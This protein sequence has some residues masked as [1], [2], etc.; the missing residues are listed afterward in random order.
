MIQ[1]EKLSIHL[2]LFFRYLREKKFLIG[3]KE[4]SDGLRALE[5]IDISDIQQ[6]RLAL[7]IV[8]CSSR[9]EQETFDHAFIKFFLNNNQDQQ[10]EDLLHVLTEKKRKNEE[11]N[12]VNRTVESKEKSST[13]PS[14]NSA[15]QDQITD[16]NSGKEQKKMAIW[17]ATNL[18]NKDEQ[19]I[20]ASISSAQFETMEK[21]AKTFVQQ[22]NLK[23]LRRYKVMKNGSKF[24]IRRTLRQSIQ[25]GGYPIKPVWTGP[26]KEKANFI[27]LCDSSRS[28]SAY[29]EPFLQFA[30]AMTKCTNNVEVFLFSTKLRRVTDQFKRT[31]QDEF[32]V[33]TIKRNEWGG[34]TCI[35]ESLY[36]FVQQYGMYVKK[37]T[38]VF[39]A[40][41]GLD[42]GAIDHLQ[43]AM[44][45]IHQ[46]TSAVIW[47]NPLL[48]IEGYEPIA[49]GMQT[50]LPYID[51]FS[52]VTTASSFQQLAHQV[53]IRR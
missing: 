43:S 38:I 37:N 26:T 8:L 18:M 29:A 11:T 49:R 5:F 46:R 12:E 24:D 27:L 14:I 20:Q 21:A 33:L 4:M 40:S 39:I 13:S 35:G 3:T 9:A 51:L 47:L 16:E 32:P 42:A 41:D 1:S 30:Y 45:E 17:T 15:R 53:Q 19:D 34:G 2:L 36:S 6:F 44:K 31:K 52:A 48:N 25:L 7:R 10:T 28:M 23:R 50:A 22:I